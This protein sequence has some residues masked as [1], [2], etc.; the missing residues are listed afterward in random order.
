MRSVQVR[1]GSEGRVGVNGQSK[2]GATPG[3]VRGRAL[4]VDDE[5]EMRYLTRLF[6]EHAFPDLDVREAESGAKALEMMDRTGFDVVVSD[7]RM[8]GMDGYSFLR[9]AGQT[10]PAKNCILMTAYADKQLRERVHA[11]GWCFVEKGGDPADI[12][13][14]V[15]RVL[16]QQVPM[17]T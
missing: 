10:I 17:R 1:A 13:E 9:Q 12:V 3:D 6:L 8:S 2:P 7:H 15:A 11:A 5:Y 4:V 14:A 16:R